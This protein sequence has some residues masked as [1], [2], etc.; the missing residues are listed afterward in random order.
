MAVLSPFTCHSRSLCASSA[1]VA[2]IFVVGMVPTSQEAAARTTFD[3]INPA[4][5]VFKQPAHWSPSGPPGNSDLARFLIAGLY[6][7]QFDENAT[8]D[9]LHVDAMGPIVFNL[10]GHA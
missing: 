8:T 4:G 1:V 7:V 6:T 9:R 3:W 10:G 5:G 2:F